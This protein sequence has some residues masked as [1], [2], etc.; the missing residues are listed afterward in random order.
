MQNARDQPRPHPLLESSRSPLVCLYL[1][2]E[3]LKLVLCVKT[4][5]SVIA[6]LWFHTVSLLKNGRRLIFTF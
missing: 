3:F 4:M 1:M 6:A 2:V 5:H